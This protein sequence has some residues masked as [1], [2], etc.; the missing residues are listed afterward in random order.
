V[1]DGVV[2]AVVLAEFVNL[3]MAVV[4]A[5]YAVVS[6]GRLNLLILEFAVFETLIFKTGLEKS[7]ATAAAVIVGAV[8]LHV[9][10]IFFTDNGFDDEPQILGNG[11]AVA[12]SN[13]LAGILYRKFY[14][15]VFVPVAVDLQFALTNPLG[16]IFID[17]FDF[18]VVLEV[19]FFQSGPD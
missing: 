13:D 3:G 5:R 15:Q 12:F 19:E 16:V 10:E 7:A 1:N 6:A 17:I 4:A 9:D 11:V 18:K 2:T 8:G 14:F